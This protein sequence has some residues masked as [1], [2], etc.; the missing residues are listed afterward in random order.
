MSTK[1]YDAPTPMRDLKKEEKD[2]ILKK[3]SRFVG[4]NIDELLGQ[5]VLQLH[6]Q[7]VLLISPELKKQTSQIGRKELICAGI[8][9]GKITKNNNFWVNVTSM[10]ILERFALHKIWLKS[11]AEMNFLYGN[12]VIRSHM[13][14][15]SGDV[16]K[17]SVVFVYNQNNTP[18][19][20]GVTA[21]SS[22]DITAS[23]GRSLVVM[24]QADTGAY[25]RNEASI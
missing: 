24:N 21:K 7:K 1:E 19:G 10:H 6:R 20:F 17:N 22:A 2:K 3:L 13:H 18:L 5:Y 9:L 25:L 8:V 16:P 4:D 12:N 23:Q 14:K 11:S 15:I